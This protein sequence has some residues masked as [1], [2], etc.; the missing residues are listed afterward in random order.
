ALFNRSPRT[1]ASSGVA[2]APTQRDT[3]SLTTVDG[4]DVIVE[5]FMAS[6]GES[7]EIWV[8]AELVDGPPASNTTAVH[9][10]Q[11]E[12]NAAFSRTNS[13]S[14][15]CRV[16]SFIGDTGPGAPTTG[17]CKAL[18]DWASSNNGYFQTTI[19]AGSK[20]WLIKSP[21]GTPC[22]FWVRHGAFSARIGNTDIRDL[23]RD[24]LSKYT[25]NFNGVYRVRARGVAHC[26]GDLVQDGSVA[27][28]WWLDNE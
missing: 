2:T 6:D 9:E 11:V 4:E 20:R 8:N 13:N 14:D 15:Q 3:T 1:S 16:S 23:I 7:Y 19:H 24:S 10:R 5:N 17:R 22:A 28:S 18:Q 25:Q 12:R 21:G 27:Y 26:N